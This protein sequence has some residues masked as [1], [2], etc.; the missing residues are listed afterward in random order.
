MNPL[1][2]AVKK[3]YGGYRA[4]NAINQRLQPQLDQARM[5]QDAMGTGYPVNVMGRTDSRFAENN[6]G[7]TDSFYETRGTYNDQ[8]DYNIYQFQE[9]LDGSGNNVPQ[10]FWK[11]SYGP[12]QITYQENQVYGGG[13]GYNQVYSSPYETA[14][15]Y[16]R[17]RIPLLNVSVPWGEYSKR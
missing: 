12:E 15:L 10:D 17:K 8:G 11:E 14:T 1:L 4:E 5:R 16:D 3:I 13:N 6:Q 2:D 7:Y 9:N